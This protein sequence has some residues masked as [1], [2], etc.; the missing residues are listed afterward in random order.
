[1]ERNRRKENEGMKKGICALILSLLLVGVITW[2]A[3]RIIVR[4]GYVN[5]VEGEVVTIITSAGSVWKWSEEEGAFTSGERVRLV[6]DNRG[7]ERIIE[8][9]VI[10]YII[11]LDK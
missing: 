4:E 6:M 3:D 5:S 9:D 10:K 8:D 2:T 7:T 11:R 1:M